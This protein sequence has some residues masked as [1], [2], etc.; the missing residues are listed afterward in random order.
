MFLKKSLLPFYFLIIAILLYSC[1]LINPD[2]EIPSYINIDKISFKT[3]FDYD[4]NSQ[5]IS[6]AW[7]RIDDLDIGAFELPA[8]FPVLSSGKHKVTIVP[9]IK[10]NGMAGMRSEYPFFKPFDTIVDL[11]KGKIAKL[12]VNTTYNSNV[13]FVWKENF[14]NPNITLKKT[15]RSDTTIKITPN[16]SP[17]SFEYG[18]N[19]FGIVNLTS[20]KS[21]FECITDTSYVLP[22]GNI[23]VFLE[24]NYRNSNPFTITIQINF[25]SGSTMQ[26]YLTINPSDE[27]K[28]IYVNLTPVANLFPNAIDYKIYFYSRIGSDDANAQKFILLDNIKL[29]TR[30]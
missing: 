17:Y 6:D 12:K 20:S 18:E 14:E 13:K 23:P 8:K 9:G 27:W 21:Y 1:E 28:K 3:K 22:H 29:I 25:F 19:S 10:L 16:V 24:I 4:V 30:S 11:V 15:P 7:V 2:E 26:E 5:D